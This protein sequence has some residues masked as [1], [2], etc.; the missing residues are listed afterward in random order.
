MGFTWFGYNYWHNDSLHI[1][2][3]MWDLYLNISGIFLRGGGGLTNQRIS[4]HRWLYIVNEPQVGF[5]GTIPFNLMHD[6]HN[7]SLLNLN[8][9]L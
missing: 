4:N 2:E 5:I 6:K 9:L 1:I 3:T 8:D 7:V